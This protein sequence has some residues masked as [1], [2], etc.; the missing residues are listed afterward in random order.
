M[1]TGTG[2][3]KASLKETAARVFN[4]MIIE[5]TGDAELQS[6]VDVDSPLWGLDI[7]QWNWNP[8][9]GVTCISNYYD[10]CQQ[11]PVQA[12]LLGWVE[13]N[14]HKMRK[15]QHVN[16]MA[17]FAIFPDLYRRTGDAYYLDTAV[18]YADWIM[19]NS[20][21]TMTGALQH[22]GDLT[23]QIWA[24]TVF[25]A[26]LFLARVGRLTGSQVLAQEAARQLLLHLEY[27]QD[28]KSGVL[29]HGYFCQDKSHHSSARWTRGNAWITVGTPLILDEIKDMLAV[30]AEIGERYRRLVD[31][32]LSFQASNGMWHTVMDQPSF[33]QE[34]SG[35]S[36]IA[37][38]ILKSIHQGLLPAESY[39]PAVEK[40][41][42]GILTTISPD[43]KVSG[44]SGGTPIMKTVEEYSR[45]S[46]YPT[47]YGQGL[48]LMLLAELAY[49]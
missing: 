16:V 47:L 12:Y 10:I 3:D 20:A 13:R 29:F 17:P 22:G 39:F 48:T 24:D 42:G 4:Y 14:K 30:P 35:S 49:R 37:C 28:P 40:A 9:V 8:G 15:F 33:Y 38:G 11:P 5:H 36:G 7:D 43:G 1:T 23:E 44:V 31:G 46:R 41:L 2:L 6:A 25:M 26:V 21:R 45:L 27:L 18:E 19:Q 34:T 32:L